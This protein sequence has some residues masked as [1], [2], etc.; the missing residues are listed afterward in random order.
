MTPN[1]G[2]EIDGGEDGGSV[3]PNVVEDV[4]AERS[5]KV[6]RVGVEV[7]DAG[8]VAKEIPFDEFLLGDP[9]FLAPVVDNCV[10]VGVTVDGEGAGGCGEEVGKNVG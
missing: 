1:F 9:E 2:A 8:E 7:S 6:E 5:N 3:D 10:L 4:G